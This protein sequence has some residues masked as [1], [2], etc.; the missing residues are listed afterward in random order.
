MHFYVIMRR[1]TGSYISSAKNEETT[2]LSMA[3]RYSTRK[4]ALAAAGPNTCVCGPYPVDD[5]EG[6]PA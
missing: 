4:R 6:K 1:E 2:F 5:Y 3:V